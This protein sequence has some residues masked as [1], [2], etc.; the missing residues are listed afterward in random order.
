MNCS[1]YTGI[2]EAGNVAFQVYKRLAFANRRLIHLIGVGLNPMSSDSN[3]KSESSSSAKPV[4]SRLSKRRLWLFRA[5][6]ATFLPLLFF[7]SIEIALGWIAI[8]YP[9]SF[10]VESED[11]GDTLVDN[12][13]FAWRFFPRSLAR[14]PQPLHVTA[15][16]PSETMRIEAVPLQSRHSSS[17]PSPASCL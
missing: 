5:L 12:Y 2:E 10:F 11:H 13:R 9:T 3:P 8:G 17:E 14:S 4:V 15:T 1:C 16:K 7:V 6:A